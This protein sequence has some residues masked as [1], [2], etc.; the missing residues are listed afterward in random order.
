MCFLKLSPSKWRSKEKIIALL[1]CIFGLVVMI[2]GT[3]QA[4]IAVVQSYS[5]DQPINNNW[6]YCNINST[7]ETICSQVMNSSLLYPSVVGVCN[8]CQQ[9]CTLANG[10][11]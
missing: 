11:Y 1:V 5:S 9:F 6:L 3:I 7:N 4:V 2:I 10:T 8:N